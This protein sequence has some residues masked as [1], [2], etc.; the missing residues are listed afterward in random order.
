M[1]YIFK[2]YKFGNRTARVQDKKNQ[3]MKG[4]RNGR[5]VV[6]REVTFN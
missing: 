2:Q 3:A 6:D 5:N 1:L 4:K